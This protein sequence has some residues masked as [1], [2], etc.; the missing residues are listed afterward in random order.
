VAESNR[1]LIFRRFAPTI[2]AFTSQYIYPD[3]LLSIVILKTSEPR[4]GLA[5]KKP[6]S[7][8]NLYALDSKNIELHSGLSKPSFSVVLAST[9]VNENITITLSTY[10][11]FFD[12]LNSF[13]LPSAIIA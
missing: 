6:M 13:I 10:D 7:T 9:C 11:G 5:E 3:F 1:L 2:P 8:Q 12:S 4:G